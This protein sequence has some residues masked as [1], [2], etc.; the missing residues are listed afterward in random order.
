[1]IRYGGEFVDEVISRAEGSW[2]TTTDGRRILDF[3]SGQMCATIGHSHP[4]VVDALSAAA[5]EVMH[6]F[7]GMLSPAVLELAEELVAALPR[8]LDKVLLVNTGS[9]SN[10]AAL[11][12]AKMHTGGFEVLAMAGSW[13]GMTSGAASSTYSAGRRGY[14]PGMPGT[15][16]LP[17]PN[18][19][20][21]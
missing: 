13:H 1:L 17:T 10:E 6:L 18:C 7:S 5:R 2:L 21:C 15:M 20:R 16:A 4:A 9:E 19:Y 12:M 11:K 8:P 3:T 14:G